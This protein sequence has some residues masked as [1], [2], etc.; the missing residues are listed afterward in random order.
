MIRQMVQDLNI[1]VGLKTCPTVREPDG[2][3]MSSRNTYL[4]HD[5][6]RAATIL[7]TALKAAQTAFNDGER[8][9]MKL[10][11]IVRKIINDEP[12]AKVQ[13][14]SCANESS[15]EEIQDRITGK[16]LLS[17]AASFGKTRLIDNILI[18]D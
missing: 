12:L 2:L 4:N 14:I 17:L 9:A 5:Q 10:R 13:Y 8:S 1:D 16:A 15:L 6:R 7:F 3:A 18:G 11:Q